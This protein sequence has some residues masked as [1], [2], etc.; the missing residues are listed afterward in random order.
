VRK[1]DNNRLSGA[2]AALITATDEHGSADLHTLDRVVDFV[3][4]HGVNGV[5]VGGGTAE[6]PHFSVAQRASTIARVRQRLN[7]SG[8]L[9]ASIGTSSIHTTLELARLA[10]QEGPDY[11][12][13]SMPYFFQYGQDDLAAFCERV[14][15]SVSVPCLLY[16]LPS[17]TAGVTV[18][19]AS[20]LLDSIPNLVGMKDSS[21]DETNL[22]PLAV[23]R[24]RI[25]VSVLVGDDSLLLPALAAGWDG[26]ISGIACFAPDLI[27]SIY[28]AY[29][30][31]RL[32]EAAA[33]QRVLDQLIEKLVRMPIPWGVR[34]GLEIRG[35][36]NGPL[37]QPVAESR[38]PA[39]ADFQA[40]VR[41]WC[42]S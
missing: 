7:G 17:F 3:M 36:P 40:W 24:S 6:Y 2:F 34:L 5:V 15:E 19:T 21:G 8:T 42:A 33:Q 1:D 27:V 14:C 26:V 13:I 18:E 16:N 41:E 4:G 38:K 11:L 39:I 10:T 20:R 22:A 31:G 35:L 25:P 9:V 23:L 28:R 29:H 12:L 30:C 37:H 32:E